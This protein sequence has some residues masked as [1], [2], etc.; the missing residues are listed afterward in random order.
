MGEWAT[1]SPGDLAAAFRGDGNEE[2]AEGKSAGKK[3][4]K[5][6]KKG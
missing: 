2:P 3:K 5:K 4:Q 6:K 1:L